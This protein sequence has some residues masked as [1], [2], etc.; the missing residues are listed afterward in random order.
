[1]AYT[2][3]HDNNTTKGWYRNDLSPD[4]HRRLEEYLGGPLKE[5]TIH[6]V[7]IRMVYSSVAQTAILPVQDVLGLDESARMNTP[8]GNEACWKW[9]L[10]PSQLTEAHQRQ[11]KK[12]AETYHRG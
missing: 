1:M 2:G 10:I 7:L 9:R 4:D 5:E 8:A 3:T 6:F 12:W 11:L